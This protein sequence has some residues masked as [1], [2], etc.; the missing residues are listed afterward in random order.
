MFQ[1][2]WSDVR[3]NPRRGRAVSNCVDRCATLI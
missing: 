3:N 1:S 2:Q